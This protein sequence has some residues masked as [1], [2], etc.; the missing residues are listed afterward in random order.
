[1]ENIYLK[2]ASHRQCSCSSLQ[3]LVSL[4]C[5]AALVSMYND[6]KELAH[7]ITYHSDR[8]NLFLQPHFMVTPVALDLPFQNFFSFAVIQLI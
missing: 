1:M 4:V 6:Q 7:N 8:G 3:R 5:K 2:L